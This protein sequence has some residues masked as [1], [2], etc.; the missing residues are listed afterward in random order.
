MK[1][2]TILGVG[3][4]SFTHPPA[5][6]EELLP[7]RRRAEAE[8]LTQE[9]GFEESDC[10]ACQS[11]DR[12]F[13]FER[14]G[15]SF[16]CCTGCRT[17]YMSPRPTAAMLQSYYQSSDY[18]AFLQSENYRNA[19][20]PFKRAQ[21]R[22]RADK[23]VMLLQETRSRE[24]GILLFAPKS[25]LLEETLVD[26]N[27]APVRT[28]PA[29]WDNSRPVE[30]RDPLEQNY[31]VIS[32]YDIFERL[33][34]PAASLKRLEASM[35]PGGRL[36]LSVRSGSGYDLLTLWQHADLCPVEHMNLITVEGMEILMDRVGLKVKE[37]S[38]PGQL[39]LQIV[40]RVRAKKA[41]KLDRFTEYFLE[42]REDFVAEAFQAFLQKGLLSSHLVVVGEKN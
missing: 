8:I 31:A 1:R 19:V 22:A 7:K 24:D 10:P 28:I 36:I 39:D 9:Q 35:N 6:L 12:E 34:D 3:E 21:G 16:H 40:Q 11:A 17:L 18:A 13:A 14:S 27:V 15:F 30:V 23:L 25:A 2:T 4:E 5:I 20:E 29:P 42:N 26:S 33:P 37:L 32:A 38:T 41:I